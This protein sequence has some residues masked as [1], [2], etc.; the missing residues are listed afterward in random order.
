MRACCAAGSALRR[1]PVVLLLLLAGQPHSE[2]ID[3]WLAQL[4]ARGQS[5]VPVDR[6]LLCQRRTRCQKFPAGAARRSGGD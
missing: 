3:A 5:A 2:V 4:D 1:P 6:C